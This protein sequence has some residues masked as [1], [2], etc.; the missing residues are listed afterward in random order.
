MVKT[1]DIIRKITR[2]FASDAH[3]DQVHFHRGPAGR[4]YACE[5][6]RCTSP[7]LDPRDIVT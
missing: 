2:V 3:A 1:D 4:T 6:P 5:D 7:A